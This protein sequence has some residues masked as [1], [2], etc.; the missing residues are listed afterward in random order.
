MRWVF[1]ETSLKVLS[2]IKKGKQMVPQKNSNDK[3]GL[4]VNRNTFGSRRNNEADDHPPHP[5]G[6]TDRGHEDGMTTGYQTPTTTTPTTTTTTRNQR[7]D[8]SAKRTKKNNGCRQISDE[9]TISMSTDT[10]GPYKK[11]DIKQFEMLRFRTTAKRKFRPTWNSCVQH[12]L[13]LRLWNLSF[14]KNLLLAN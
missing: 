2:S 10:Y 9:T 4:T 7:Q 13:D 3:V 5:C 14:L 1:S 12:F 11:K 6:R 8:A